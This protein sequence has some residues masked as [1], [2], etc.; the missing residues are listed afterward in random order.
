MCAARATVAGGRV[1]SKDLCREK[2]G[3]KGQQRQRSRQHCP[4]EIGSKSLVGIRDRTI[5]T[6]PAAATLFFFC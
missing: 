3:E 2:R 6:V 1:K 4:F 5:R